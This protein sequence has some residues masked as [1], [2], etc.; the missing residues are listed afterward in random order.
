MNLKILFYLLYMLLPKEVNVFP[1]WR[2]LE[3]FAKNVN[4][5]WVLLLGDFNDLLNGDEKLGGLPVNL[6]RVRIFQE[7]L[8][9]CGLMDLGLL[10]PR[11]TWTS[12]HRV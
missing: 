3:D 6:Y 12:K 7:Y 4:I 5:P 10:G 2:Q 8:D 9:K 11:Y 1:L